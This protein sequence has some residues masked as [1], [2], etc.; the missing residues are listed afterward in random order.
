MG[1][2]AEVPV[3]AQKRLVCLLFAW[4]EECIRWRLLEEE[5]VE[6]GV[7]LEAER[8]MGGEGRV[9]ELEKRLLE[10]RGLMGVKPSLRGG[11]G[12]EELPGYSV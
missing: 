7:V 5:E 10:I 8:G 3:F 6:I 11:V 9:E 2:F 1:K 12:G 4:E